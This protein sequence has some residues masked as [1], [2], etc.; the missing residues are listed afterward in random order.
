MPAKNV[1]IKTIYKKLNS[2]GGSQESLPDTE[3][4]RTAI[5]QMITFSVLMIFILYVGMHLKR[6]YFRRKRYH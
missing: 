4:E 5:I 3:E 1:L 2:G 6:K